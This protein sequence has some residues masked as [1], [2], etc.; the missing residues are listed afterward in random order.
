MSVSQLSQ[1]SRSPCSRIR[2]TH[3]QIYITTQAG[4]Y[5]TSGT[6]VQFKNGNIP[7][8]YFRSQD[9]FCRSQ[10]RYFLLSWTSMKEGF[11]FARNSIASFHSF[12]FSKIKNWALGTDFPVP[13][14]QS[15]TLVLS[16]KW[17]KEN[18]ARP[19]FSLLPPIFGTVRWIARHSFPLNPQIT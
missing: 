18:L 6:D 5:H 2:G 12:W 17:V 9:L 4:S 10:M 11:G 13:H 1:W 7:T 19:S 3:T 8:W 15:L 16:H 14:W